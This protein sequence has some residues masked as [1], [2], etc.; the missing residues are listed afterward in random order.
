MEKIVKVFNKTEA[1]ITRITAVMV[2]LLTIFVSIQVFTRYVLNKGQFWAEE[3]SVITMMWIGFLGAS[4]GVWTNS[5][6]GLR[7]FIE[8]LPDI[9]RKIV[10]IVNHIIIAG[11]SLLL[12]YYGTV[13]VKRTMSGTLSATKI[14]IGYSYLIIP[15]ATAFMTIFSLLKII[16]LIFKISHKDEI[17]SGG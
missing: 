5:H 17:Y 6:I 9:L 4:G 2:I 11:F 3:V 10:E 14:P 12:F 1:I 15:I 8:R 13:L 16:L 7:L